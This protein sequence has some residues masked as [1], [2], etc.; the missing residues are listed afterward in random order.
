MVIVTVINVIEQAL[1]V[2][3]LAKVIL[4]YVMNP[5]H[6]VRRTVDSIVEPMLNPIR[7]VI[8]FIG[9]FDF[10]PIVLILLIEIAASLLRGILL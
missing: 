6:P 4:S 9:G 8:P 7:Q 1:L 2:L 3:I 10:S 5:F